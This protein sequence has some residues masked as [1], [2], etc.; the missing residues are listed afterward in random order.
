MNYAEVNST[1]K[2]ALKKAKQHSIFSNHWEA[3][4]KVLSS[5]AVG[6]ES[7][8]N[9]GS[10]DSFI[11]QSSVFSMLLDQLDIDELSL[12]DLTF[13]SQAAKAIEDGDSKAATFVRDTSGGKPVD[14]QVSVTNKMTELPDEAIDYLLEHSVIEGDDNEDDE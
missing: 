7:L 5:L 14:K 3:S 2:I 4:G 12:A 9:L 1:T 11:Q 10:G 13:L 8:K 6:K